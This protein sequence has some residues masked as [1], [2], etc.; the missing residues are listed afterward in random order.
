MGSSYE[1]GNNILCDFLLQLQLLGND[2]THKDYQEGIL[3]N[4][5][6]LLQGIGVPYDDLQYLDFGLKSESPAHVRVLAYNIVSALWFSGIFP[7]NCEVAYLNNST[8]IGGIRYKFNKKT[9]RLSW[10]KVKGKG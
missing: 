5:M 2:I 10:V 3:E 8:V 4:S 6:Y 1:F 9:K 7:E